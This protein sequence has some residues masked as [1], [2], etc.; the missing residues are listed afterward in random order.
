MKRLIQRA[1]ATCSEIHLICWP[2]SFQ[3]TSHAIRIRGAGAHLLLPDAAKRLVQRGDPAGSSVRVGSLHKSSSSIDRNSAGKPVTKLHS[4]ITS[5]SHGSLRKTCQVILYAFEALY[6][7]EFLFDAGHQSGRYAARLRY[8]R[9]NRWSPVKRNA[10]IVAFTSDATVD[11]D[12]RL[13]SS[14]MRLRARFLP[15]FRPFE[16]Q[17]EKLLA[18]DPEFL[19]TMPSNLEG[20]LQV[21][22]SRHLRLRSLNCIFSGGEVLEDWLRVRTRELLGVE[23]RDNYGST[24]GFAAWQCPAGTITSMPSILF[25]RS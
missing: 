9:A 7:M 24:E 15:I 14:R 6:G 17:V 1:E 16:E 8:L 19:Y 5:A 25:S 18:V 22:E 11:L 13:V 12:S 21:F 20:L 4:E 10:W 3:K 2:P 23:I